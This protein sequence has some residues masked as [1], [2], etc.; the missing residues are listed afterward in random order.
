V[1]ERAAKERQKRKP[2]SVQEIVPE[3]NAGKTSGRGQKDV[4]IVPQPNGGKT[5][6]QVGEI[7]GVSADGE[8]LMN[9]A[10]RRNPKPPHAAGA[11]RRVS[12][13]GYDPEDLKPAAGQPA[14]SRIERPTDFA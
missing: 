13:D 7:Y 8:L 6:D 3:Q 10:K 1:E 2:D 4:E 14:N 5:R 12:V 11:A 9:R